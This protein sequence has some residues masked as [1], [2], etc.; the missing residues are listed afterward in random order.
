MT[1]LEVVLLYLVFGRHSLK[2]EDII[3][4][5]IV[6]FHDRGCE[7]DIYVDFSMKLWRI[8]EKVREIAR[9]A[10]ICRHHQPIISTV[11]SGAALGGFVTP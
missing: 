7:V 10:L 9:I 11:L 5:S 4:F 3:L 6:V 2:V 8:E 1:S